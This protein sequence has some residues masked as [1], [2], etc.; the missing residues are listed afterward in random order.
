MV[1]GLTIHWGGKNPYNPDEPRLPNQG[2]G[3][4]E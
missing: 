3:F 2:E 4:E 1:A